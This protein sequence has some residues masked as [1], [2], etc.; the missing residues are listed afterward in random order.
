MGNGRQKQ[1]R[2]LLKGLI[3][4]AWAGLV[5]A[6]GLGLG[7]VLRL[8]GSGG[9]AAPTRV[10]FDPAQLP[11]AGKVAVK[12]GAALARDS[13]GLFAL[14]L[15]CPHLGCRPVFHPDQGRFLCPCHG[16]AFAADGS[17]LKGPAQRG[18]G[19]LMLEKTGDQV[20][21]ALDRPAPPGFR[22]SM[23]GKS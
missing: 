17:L 2:L 9:P 6:A 8:A 21:V 18:L 12:D 15:T 7:A 16:S 4:A 22:L 20:V 23:G 19:R 5:G 11:A 10:A 13:R 14:S 1:R 3:A